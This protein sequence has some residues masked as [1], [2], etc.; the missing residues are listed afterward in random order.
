MSVTS[1]NEVA[2]TGETVSTPRHH[3]GNVREAAEQYGFREREIIDFSANVNPLGPSPA[4][5]RAARKALTCIDRY[6]DP[7]MTELR[8]GIAAYFGVGPGQVACG[9][10]STALIHLIP[11]VFRP[12]R[13]LIP[14]PTFSEYTA[15]VEDAGGEVVPFI[16]DARKGFRIDAVDMA[17]ALKGVD[18]AFLCNPNNPSGL[19]VPEDEMREI[20]GYALREGVRLVID[21]TFIDFI[22]TGSLL[23][24]AAGSSHIICLRAFTKFFGMPGLRVGYAVGGEETIGALTD[25]QE[26]WSV[27]TPASKAALAAL[28]DWRYIRKTRKLIARERDRLLAALRLLPGTDATPGA[29]NFLLVRFASRESSELTHALAQRGILVRDCSSFPALGSRYLRVA[30]RTRRENERLIYAMRNIL[31]RPQS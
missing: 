12:R 27:S 24:E 6:P 29:A 21:E 16:L 11:R 9:N 17:F 23:Q 10:G 5:R 7:A 4:A 3:G 1:E 22:G 26:P 13:V 18:M 30:V 25:A 14:M 19:L 31:L 8:C 20:A 2:V 15:A 28:H